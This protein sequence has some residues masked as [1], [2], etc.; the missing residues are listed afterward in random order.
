MSRAVDLMKKKEKEGGRTADRRRE[1]GRR[2]L[3][4]FVQAIK[5]NEWVGPAAE[6]Y[7]NR[8]PEHEQQQ[9]KEREEKGC[10]QTR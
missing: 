9:R 10:L 6:I 1:R 3:S 2:L 5:A 7:A 8:L 4:L